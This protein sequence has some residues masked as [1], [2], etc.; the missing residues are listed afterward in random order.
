MRRRSY[1]ESNEIVTSLLTCLPTA[2]AE[3]N[4]RILPGQD[5]TVRI[6]STH[7]GCPQAGF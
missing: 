3:P 5:H 2:D 6:Y 4:D 1:K 7:G